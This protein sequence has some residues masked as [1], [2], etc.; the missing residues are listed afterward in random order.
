MRINFHYNLQHITLNISDQAIGRANIF[1]RKVD[2]FIASEPLQFI[3][4]LDSKLIL[5]I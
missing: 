2:Q 3:N 5:L 4:W 1:I